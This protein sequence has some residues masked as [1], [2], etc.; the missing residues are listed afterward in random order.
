MTAIE[1]VDYVLS[2]EAEDI[3]TFRNPYQYHISGKIGK[4]DFELYYHIED[5]KIKGTWIILDDK[6]D[7]PIWEICNEFDKR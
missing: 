7:I 6:Y 5:N 3:S 4:D 1:I 2:H